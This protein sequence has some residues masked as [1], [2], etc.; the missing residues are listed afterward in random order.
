VS[1]AELPPAA[2]P[3]DESPAA[4]SKTLLYAGMAAMLISLLFTWWSLNKY[5]VWEQ[6][7][8]DMGARD[9][10]A[11]IEKGMDPDELKEYQDRQDRYRREWELNRNR[12]GKFYSAQFGEMYDTQLVQDDLYTKRSGSLVLRGWSTWTGWLSLVVIACVL[13]LPYAPNYDRDW[14]PFAWTI[15]WIQTTLLGGLLMFAAAFYLMMPDANGDGYAQGIGLGFYLM[16]A[17]SAT[18]LSVTIRDALRSTA[19]H[20]A[21]AVDEEDEEPEET[22]KPVKNRLQDW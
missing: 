10:A 7:G 4:P 3:A 19:E 20:R 16:F 1:Q 9:A 11:E 5:R 21:Q 12:F 14:K 6:R 2:E 18:A 22:P 15:P 8:V 17:G 13:A